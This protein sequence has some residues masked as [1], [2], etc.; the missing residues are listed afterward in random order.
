MAI[1][2]LTIAIC[3]VPQRLS[4]AL[5]SK[6]ITSG[7]SAAG[8]HRLAGFDPRGDGA[9]CRGAQQRGRGGRRV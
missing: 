5:Y 3:N 7:V 6:M 1:E 4:S 9:A 8:P 2:C